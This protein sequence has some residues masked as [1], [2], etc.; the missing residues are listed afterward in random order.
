MLQQ[1]SVIRDTTPTRNKGL[2][3]TQHDT[4]NSNQS[5]GIQLQLEIKGYPRH[6]MIQQQSVTRDTTPT[7]NK[8]L[9]ATQHDTT[10]VS[11]NKDTTPTRNEGLSATQHDTTAV[12]HK[13]YNA[14]TK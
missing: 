11:H 1:Q 6:N 12:S 3:A 9:P 13:G 5:Q 10:A 7:R 8:G 2:P 4:L 14:N